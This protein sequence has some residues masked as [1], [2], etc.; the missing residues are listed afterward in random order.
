MTGWTFL[1]LIITAP[2]C[3]L[4][5]AAT[6]LALQAAADRHELKERAARGNPQGETL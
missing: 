6:V 5:G 4:A 2:A 3:Y 1:A